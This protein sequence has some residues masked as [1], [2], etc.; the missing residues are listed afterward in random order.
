LCSH[1]HPYPYEVAIG[2]DPLW[3]DPLWQ[4]LASSQEAWGAVGTVS[5]TKHNTANNDNRSY[6]GRSTLPIAA[7]CSAR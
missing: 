4:D 7:T 5:A 6:A 3:Q 1:L 2:W